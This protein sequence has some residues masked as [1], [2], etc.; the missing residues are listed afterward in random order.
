VATAVERAIALQPLVR[1]HADTSEAQRHLQA[2]VAQAFAQ[3]GLYRIAAPQEWHGS[4]Q[5]PLTQVETI[6]AIAQA[7]GSAAWNLM[8]GIE[9]FGL[10]APGF[11]HCKELLADPLMVMCSSTAAVGRADKVDGGYRV[12]GRWA[13]VSGC[14]NSEIFG[15][16]VRVWEDGAMV[17]E[18]PN[19]YAIILQPDWEI[20]DTWHTGGLCGSG[21]HD[22][23]VEDVFVPDERFILPMGG[24][25]HDSALLSFPLG[26]RLAYNKL[27]VSWGM[28]RTA[29]DAFVELAEGKMPRF[30]SRG[31]KQRPRAQ[32]AVAEAEVRFSAGRALVVELLEQMWAQVQ[33][34]EHITTRERGMFQLACSDSVRG[35]IQAVNTL[36][37]AAGTSANQKGHPLERI[38]RDIR[39]VG[40]HV[41]VAPH[42]IEDAG[43]IMLGLPAQEMMLAGLRGMDPAK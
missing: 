22:V 19:H 17:A 31:L 4:A 29:I 2:E 38:Q 25:K 10:V 23:V 33:Q 26:A 39:V 16:T 1:T 24:T 27:G 3:E 14:H 5:D 37:E 30:S 43:R 28:T 42:H 6:E 41:T 11:L 12:S 18:Q 35:C 32:R 21:S 9:T 40:Q 15:A 13:F 7:D 8:I 34:R 20:L 36:C